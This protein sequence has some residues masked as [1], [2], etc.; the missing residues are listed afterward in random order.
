[1]M[2]ANTPYVTIAGIV[3]AMGIAARAQSPAPCTLGITKYL[4]AAS[5]LMSGHPYSATIKET[6]EQKLGDGNSIHSVTRTKQARD[7]TG[8]T[9]SEFAVECL[10]GEDG[11]PE[12][13]LNVRVTDPVAK[14]SLRWQ[15]NGMT[16]KVV[17]ISHY[18]D[19]TPLTDDM[20]E[21]QKMMQIHQPSRNEFHTE[22][23]GSKTIC[24]MV[25]EGS[26][27]VRTI[28]AGEE[29]N[30]QPLE[31]IDETWRS[32]E[33][34]FAL[35]MINDDPRRGRTTIEYEAL[36]LGEPDPALFSPPA[37]YKIEEQV[38]KVVAPVAIR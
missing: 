28:P 10:R 6:F 33:L 5:M 19:S 4:G 27:R 20:A 25:V 37:D 34:G 2:T 18:L 35:M 16:P 22:K 7:S 32:R 17:R 12:L 14:E 11:Q 9:M 26:R 24:G 3:M 38:M 15:V 21:R 31:V 30:E 1:M 13:M 29:G 36:N 8:K 23:L